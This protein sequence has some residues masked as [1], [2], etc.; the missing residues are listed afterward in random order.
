MDNWRKSS[1]SSQSGGNCVEVASGGDI[2]VRDTTNRE[3]FT[4]SVSAGAWLKFTSGIK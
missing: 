1:H 4:L 3:G 2:M